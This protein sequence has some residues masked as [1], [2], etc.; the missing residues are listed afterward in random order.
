MAR[1]P[2][3]STPRPGMPTRR[4]SRIAGSGPARMAGTITYAANVDWVA[5]AEVLRQPA[6]RLLRVRH[7]LAGRVRRHGARSTALPSRTR[8]PA[9]PARRRAPSPRSRRTCSRSAVMPTTSRPAV[10][11]RTATIALTSTSTRP[12]FKSLAG[13]HQFKFGARY[14]RL[15]NDVDSGAQLPTVSLNWNRAFTT[16]DGRTMRGAYGYYTITR[17]LHAGRGQLEQLELLGAGQLD[18]QEQLHNQR[19]RAHRERACAVVS[20]PAD[21]GIEFGFRDKIAPRLGF[22]YDVKGDGKWKTY[23]S[24]GRLLRHHQAGDAAR[25]VRRRSLDHLLLHAR[26]LQLAERSTAPT[27]RRA[28]RAPTSPR[29]ICATPP[30]RRIRG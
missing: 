20:D 28:A 27:A 5:H 30:T 6:E 26:H 21:P 22:A 29:S 17:S 11:C 15:G 10:R 1:R 18:D 7:H 19:R 14:E 13:E 16:A 3:A 24:F 9:R 25:L 2:T 12:W 4:S 23:G 8:A